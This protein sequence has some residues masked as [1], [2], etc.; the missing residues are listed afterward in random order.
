MLEL[1]IMGIFGI[2]TL[3]VWGVVALGGWIEKK[4]DQHD[5]FKLMRF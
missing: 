4:A 1:Y 3:A 5:K 2:V